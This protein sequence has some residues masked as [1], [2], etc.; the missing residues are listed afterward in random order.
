MSEC[1][2]WKVAKREGAIRYSTGKPCKRGHI[3]DRF[4]SSRQCVECQAIRTLKYN[5]SEKG[6]L[7]AKERHIRKSYSLTLQSVRG[8][9]N[10]QI[11]EVVLDDTRGK[12]G[13]CVDHD[14]KTGKIRGV[15]CGNC[16]RALGMMQDDLERLLKAAQY[17]KA[18]KEVPEQWFKL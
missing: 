12:F 6:K 9:T 1:G 3:S 4:T 2:S 7:A 15:L 5:R 14:H 13:R 8:V 11:C 18:D 16:N 17:L 10:C